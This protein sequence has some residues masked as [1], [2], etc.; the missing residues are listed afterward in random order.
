MS[1][2]GEGSGGARGRGE[3]LRKG[4]EECTK[5]SAVPTEVEGVVHE[6]NDG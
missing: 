4:T 3:S 1:K 5:W 2:H 6:G